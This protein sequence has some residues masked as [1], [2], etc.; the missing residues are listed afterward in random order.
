[1]KLDKTRITIRERGLLATMDLALHVCREYFAQ[2]VIALSLAVVPLSLINFAL[3]GWML[4]AET[5]DD[6]AIHPLVT[7]LEFGEEQ[8]SLLRFLLNLAA[9]I[10]LE[11]PLLSIP[12]VAF[13][14]PAVFQ[15]TRK[16]GQIIRD[17]ARHWVQL[18][19]TQ[20]ILRGVAPAWIMYALIDREVPT[21]RELGFVALIM[22]FA[23]AVRSFRPYTAEIILLEHSPLF[24]RNPLIQ[25]L[26]KRSKLLHDARGDLFGRT[27]MATQLARLM[28]L[29]LLMTWAAGFVILFNESLFSPWAVAWLLPLPVWLG[30]GYLAVVRFLSYLDVRI[31]NEGWEV[32]LLLKAE[33]E[34]LQSRIV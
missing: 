26:G 25:S 29:A 28:T 2:L 18:A 34:R 14:G 7:G 3:L 31:R 8:A 24:S 5:P 30:G 17:V 32:E 9:L 21:E 16:P 10:Y 22:L 1:M 4:K 6:G 20:L 15:E 33:G 27:L 19:W 13:L 11:S 12:I 23:A